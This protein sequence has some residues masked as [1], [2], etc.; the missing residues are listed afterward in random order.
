M[1]GL[2]LAD[3][4]YRYR[5]FSIAVIGAGVVLAMALLLSGLA[6]G[7]RQEIKLTVG[8]V[9]AD[10]WVLAANA[11][12]RIAAAS[13][14]PESDASVIASTVGVE[15]SDP[16]VIVP[17]QVGRIAGAT[18][19]V[20]VFGVVRGGLG[21]PKPSSGHRLTG[22]GQVVASTASKARIGG[23]IGI[24]SMH[25]TVVG[26][27]ADRTL[28]AGG[29]IM[30]V[31][32]HDAQSLAFEGKALVTAVVTSGSPE[33]LP[34]GL[35]V[36]TTSDIEHHAVSA[37][38]GAIKSI[39]NSKFFMWFIAAII[40]SALLYVSALQRVRDFAVLKA[41]GSSSAT[42][43]FSLA[44]QAVL[45][46]LLAAG[47]G[48]VLSNFMGGVF[49][50][51]VAIPASAFETIPLVAIVVGFVSSLFALRRATSADPASAFGG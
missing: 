33:S 35:A 22:D 5:Q 50:Q 43:F 7:F 20:N 18:P 32:V 24:G 47:L 44:V 49:A 39:D 23:V 10:H 19:T 28:L 31:S 2:T 36:Y 26:R 25:F 4:R 8:G 6:G 16:L 42:L 46:A 21:D 17:Q 51:P 3:L 9:G 29:P 30:Y 13:A 11:D 41:L 27:V 38:A 40:I 45:V 14:F 15:R 48:V 1:L 34:A 37:L 12:G